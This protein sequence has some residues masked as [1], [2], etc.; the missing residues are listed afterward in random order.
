MRI[1][2]NE[3]SE[4]AAAAGIAVQISHGAIGFDAHVATEIE[5][6]G[7]ARSVHGTRSV[8]SIGRVGETRAGLAH[9]DGPTQLHA[10]AVT[11]QEITRQ[12]A[13]GYLVQPTRSALRIG[14]QR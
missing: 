10:H 6:V 12:R 8:H 3:N 5:L 2:W 13:T 7:V 14:A 4:P 1:E 11:G 9:R